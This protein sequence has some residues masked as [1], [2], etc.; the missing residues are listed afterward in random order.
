MGA[1][2]VHGAATVTKAVR[3]RRDCGTK[4]GPV[5]SFKMKDRSRRA[6]WMSVPGRKWSAG[7][8]AF[9][10]GFNW[11]AQ[12]A[13]H[14][15]PTAAACLHS[16]LIASGAVSWFLARACTAWIVAEPSQEHHRLQ[17]LIYGD[18]RC[19][20]DRL[21]PNPL[22]PLRLTGRIFTVSTKDRSLLLDHL[23]RAHQQRLR[24]RQA[25]RLGGLQINHELGLRRLL[26]RKLARFGAFQDLVDIR[27]RTAG[28][29]A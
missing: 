25:E 29:V 19:C 26:D 13:L 22:R 7:M 3:S 5:V 18:G 27:C 4:V 24:D 8:A 9:D 12:H 1:Q 17:T 11:S 20:V 14:W 15:R 16:V 23:I 28:A 2:T 21:S 10:C 6:R